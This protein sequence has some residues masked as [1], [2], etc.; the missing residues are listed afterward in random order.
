MTRHATPG[1][2]LGLVLGEAARKMGKLHR[3]A[4]AD[5]DSD[6]P[7][8]M[9]LTLLAQRT[10]PTPVEQLVVELDRRMDLARP[11]VIGLLERTAAAGYITRVPGEPVHAVALTD[12]GSAH[13]ASLYAHARK[14]TD[15]A[16]ADI[17]PATVDA[18]ITVLLAVDARATSLLG[19]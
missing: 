1:P 19:S 14:C 16:S 3:R 17:D 7:S 4:L 5:L 6:F 11:H 13:Y 18:A 8:W 10:S 9:L 12:S 15:A 2:S